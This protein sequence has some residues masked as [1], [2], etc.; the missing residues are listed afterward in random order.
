ML[1]GL[2]LVGPPP[3]LSRD[4]QPSELRNGQASFSLALPPRGE[5]VRRQNHGRGVRIVLAVHGRE[6]TY[7]RVATPRWGSRFQAQPRQQGF[8]ENDLPLRVIGN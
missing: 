4:K 1:F 3:Q 6:C 5:L 7:V 8:G 2:R